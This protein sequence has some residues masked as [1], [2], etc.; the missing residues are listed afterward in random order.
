MITHAS[1]ALFKWTKTPLLLFCAFGLLA[2]LW[3]AVMEAVLRHPGYEARAIQAAAIA[4]TSAFIAIVLLAGTRR[5][6]PWALVAAAACWL[7]V[8]GI[9]SLVNVAHASH[10]EGYVAVIGAGLVAQALL[11]LTAVLSAS[12][13]PHS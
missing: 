2:G 5:L 7:G 13:A 10:F 6:L 12:R 9:S 4:A 3:L 8:V 11:A 1:N